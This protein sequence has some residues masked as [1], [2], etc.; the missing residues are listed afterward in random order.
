MVSWNVN[1]LSGDRFLNMFYAGVM[2]A[3]SLLLFYGLVRYKGRCQSYVATMGLV[4]VSTAAT[5]FLY[6]C[7]LLL[8][9]LR[10][11]YCH[12]STDS[13]KFV[14][15]VETNVLILLQGTEPKNSFLVANMQKIN[16]VL[17][18]QNKNRT[19]KYSW[20]YRM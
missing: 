15:L 11:R 8:V 16:Q 1:S 10:N 7:M 9:V 3:A 14:C 2:E 20:R 6:Q 13:L 18:F 17:V 19:L 4:G 12:F 5:A